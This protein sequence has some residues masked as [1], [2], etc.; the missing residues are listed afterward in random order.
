MVETLTVNSATFAAMRK[1]A[2]CAEIENS[3]PTIAALKAAGIDIFAR[4]VLP[5]GI[6]VVVQD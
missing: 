2:M 4:E 3:D 5:P 6:K 1:A